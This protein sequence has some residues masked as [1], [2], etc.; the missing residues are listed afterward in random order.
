MV[1]TP[2]EYSRISIMNALLMSLVKTL[3]LISWIR[4]VKLIPQ[5][6][7]CLR[8]FRFNL[9]LDNQ[10]MG[11][12]LISDRNSSINYKCGA[13][14]CRQAALHG[15]ILIDVM[16]SVLGSIALSMNLRAVAFLQAHPPAFLLTQSKR[17]TKLPVVVVVVV[18]TADSSFKAN[19]WQTQTHPNYTQTS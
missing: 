8:A 2:I 7:E 14:T 12:Y 4:G 3:T 13:K 16:K 11:V 1:Y 9:V 10:V 18:S 6:A 19:K 15:M 5:R 17:T